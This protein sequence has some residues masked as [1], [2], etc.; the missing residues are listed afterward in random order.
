M[1]C[2]HTHKACVSEYGSEYDELGQP[3]T[4]VEDSDVKKD[5]SGNT[6]LAG[7]SINLN[8][9]VA[10]IMFNTENDILNETAIPLF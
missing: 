4:I 6:F 7:T 8:E 10:N 2:G 1:L 5:E 9:G 3:C